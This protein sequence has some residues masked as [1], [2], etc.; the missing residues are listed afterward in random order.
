MNDTVYASLNTFVRIKENQLLSKE[1]FDTLLK[2]QSLNHAFNQLKS[3]IYSEL[4]EQFEEQLM[5][6]LTDT[7]AQLKQET[8]KQEVLDVFTLVY[9]YHNL[10]ILLK[11]H[12]ANM[13]LM[14]L[15]IPIGRY[16]KDALEQLAKTGTSDVLPKIMVDEVYHAIA[17]YKEYGQI[18][19]LDILMDRA[20]FIHL[21]H[22]VDD[23]EQPEVKKI[24]TAWA[25][26]YNL[27]CVLRTLHKKV[28]RSFLL[29]ILSQTGSMDINI[30]VE[31][32]MSNRLSD[33]F[34]MYREKDFSTVLPDIFSVDTC[35]S[36][37]VE[38]ARDS[39]AHYYLS[40]APYQA[41]GM[42]PVLSYMYYKEMEIKNLRL[43]LTGKDN[44]MD[45]A[46]LKERMRPIYY[47][48]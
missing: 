1:T 6:I 48:L 8:P 17:H 40:N 33:L 27:N 35:S 16:E 34:A 10:K 11:T 14:P 38:K 36:I 7:Y 25:D 26:L 37:D 23:L 21:K 12:I 46:V 24:V 47:G 20:Y 41:F 39:I 45:E 18:Q 2:A 3:T 13:S 9:T 44:D 5:S 32:A 4:T 22:I 19:A 30:I 42:L 31:L 15:L 29:S 28:S 43:I